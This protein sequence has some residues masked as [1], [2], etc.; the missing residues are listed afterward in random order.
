MYPSQE[1]NWAVT[2]AVNGTFLFVEE[3]FFSVIKRH[4]NKRLWFHKQWCNVVW[5]ILLWHSDCSDY[6]DMLD[7][8]FT[9][10]CLQPTHSCTCKE[11]KKKTLFF[12]TICSK[13]ERCHH[14][15]P[16]VYARSKEDEFVLVTV[17]Y[18]KEIRLLCCA[19]TYFKHGRATYSPCGL[20]SV[21]W[22][23]SQASSS[24]VI[25]LGWV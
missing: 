14:K 6:N 9:I 24:C 8:C 18:S 11:L 16:L 12:S 10:F 22:I 13:K 4:L 20:K 1:E 21:H 5:E 17:L 3:L 2:S 23:I 19:L 15:N 25:I 7:F